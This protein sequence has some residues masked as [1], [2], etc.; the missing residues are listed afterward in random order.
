MGPAGGISGPQRQRVGCPGH[1]GSSR[2]RR[3]SNRWPV[4]LCHFSRDGSVA[5]ELLTYVN[6]TS[7]D[8]YPPKQT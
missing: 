7:C 3:D 2:K 6:G 5:F 4:P 8:G 1:T